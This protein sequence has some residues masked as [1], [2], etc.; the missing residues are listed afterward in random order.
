MMLLLP[1]AAKA[2]P[3][4]PPNPPPQLEEEAEGNLQQCLL[5]QAENTKL[6]AALRALETET[7]HR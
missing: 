6:K 5:L 1:M 2:N 4:L 3:P 7:S